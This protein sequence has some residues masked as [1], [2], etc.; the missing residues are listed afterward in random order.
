MTLLEKFRIHVNTGLGTVN[1]LDYEKVAE[2]SDEEFATLYLELMTEYEE[3][4]QWWSKG[5]IPKCHECNLSITNP[6]KLR[7]YYGQSLHPNCFNVVYEREGIHEQE[8]GLVKKY[9]ERVSKLY[10]D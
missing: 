3:K 8:S 5:K 6:K 4:N 10:Y 9:W 2:I 1:S 7:R